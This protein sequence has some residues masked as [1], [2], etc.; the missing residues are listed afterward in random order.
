MSIPSFVVALVV[1]IMGTYFITA[2]YPH[3]RFL[4]TDHLSPSSAASWATS[5]TRR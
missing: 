1:F 3:L 2:D 4:V 5:S